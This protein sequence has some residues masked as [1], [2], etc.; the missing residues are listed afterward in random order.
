MLAEAI[1]GAQASEYYTI[2]MANAGDSKKRA[3]WAGKIKSKLE[4]QVFHCCI[5]SYCLLPYFRL[6]TKFKLAQKAMGETG[7]GLTSVEQID[8]SQKN[9]LTT[10]WCACSYLSFF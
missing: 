10:A 4:E 1:F 8:M 7:P 5:D 3:W 9:L 6:T 2:F